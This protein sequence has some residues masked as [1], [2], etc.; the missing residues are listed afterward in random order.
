MTENRGV[1]DMRKGA[2]MVSL[3]VIFLIIVY[4]LSKIWIILSIRMKGYP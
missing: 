1:N 3:L 2:L 4:L